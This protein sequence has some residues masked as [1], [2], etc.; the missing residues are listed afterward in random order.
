MDQGPHRWGVKYMIKKLIVAVILV[1][2]AAYLVNNWL[3]DRKEKQAALDA[4][5]R[6]SEEIVNSVDSI[7]KESNAI[8]NWDIVLTRGDSSFRY[9]P[10]LTIELQKLW[11][12]DRPI[13][14]VGKICDVSRESDSLYVVTVQRGDL[15]SKVHFFGTELFVSLRCSKSLADTILATMIP[16]DW[17]NSNGV[18]VVARIA[19][20]LSTRQFDKEGEAIQTIT[21]E[22]DLLAIVP[23]GDVF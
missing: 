17:T 19:R 4:R 5:K 11:L 13:L 22:G 9:T 2:V 12:V 7:A 8:G 18:A 10:V 6:H 16:V 1:A 23:T 3:K 21:G 20:V 15:G 14:F